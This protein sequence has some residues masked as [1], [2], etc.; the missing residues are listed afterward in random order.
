MSS[1]LFHTPAS[2]VKHCAFVTQEPICIET[3]P[4]FYPNTRLDVLGKRD[5]N[6]LHQFKFV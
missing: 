2:R 3:D 5:D 6:I 1:P 4:F